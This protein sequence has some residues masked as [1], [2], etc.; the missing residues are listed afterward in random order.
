MASVW[1]SWRQ[2]DASDRTD[3]KKENWY[4][5]FESVLKGGTEEEGLATME[6][7][8]IKYVRPMDTRTYLNYTLEYSM[9]R[10]DYWIYQ[11]LKAEMRLVESHRNHLSAL[12]LI[13][14]STM[15]VEGQIDPTDPICSDMTK[16]AGTN[17]IRGPLHGWL[18]SGVWSGD[19]RTW[20]GWNYSPRMAWSEY[21]A[22]DWIRAIGCRC[23]IL[24]QIG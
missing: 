2:F 16:K 8:L 22:I 21:M 1:R 18:K 9:M 20:E 17:G 12:R 13:T 19:G 4:D 23:V 24:A 6:E 15:R 7:F 11:W 10:E 5:I 3:K 14:M